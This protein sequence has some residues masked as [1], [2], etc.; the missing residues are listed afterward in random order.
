MH[1]PKKKFID[2]GMVLP[3]TKGKEK[4]VHTNILFCAAA[5]RQEISDETD[6]ETGRTKQISGVPIHLS[7]YSPNGMQLLKDYYMGNNKS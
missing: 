4:I 2:F 6:R 1:L 7:I 5:V 3:K